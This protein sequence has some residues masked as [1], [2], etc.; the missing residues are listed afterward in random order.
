[1]LRPAHGYHPLRSSLGAGLGI[2]VCLVVGAWLVTNLG[3]PLALVAPIGA[4]AVLV[5]AV[6]ASPLAQPRAVMGGNLISAL[7][8]LLLSRTG[9]PPFAMA[10]MATALAIMAMHILRC[11]HPPGG[12]MALVAAMGAQ[13]TVWPWSFLL[14]PVAINSLTLLAIGWLFN[15]A[16]GSRYPH[17]NEVLPEHRLPIAIDYDRADLDVVLDELEDRPDISVEDLDAIIRAVLIRHK[18]G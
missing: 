12:A 13:G 2:G 8:G 16:T 7:I 5:F 14:L 9:L 15:N 18:A 6:P 3:F 17:H 10:A 1:M 11:L 4:S